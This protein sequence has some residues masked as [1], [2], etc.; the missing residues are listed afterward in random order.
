MLPFAALLQQVS[1]QILFVEPLHDDDDGP[2]F[3]VIQSAVKRLVKPRVGSLTQHVRCGFFRVQRVVHYQPVS[4]LTCRSTAN[5]RGNHVSTLVIKKLRLEVVVL[6]QLE[7]VAPPRLIPVG[8]NDGAP[9]HAVLRGQALRVT[10]ENPPRFRV[11]NPLPHRPHHRHR[12]GLHV[13]RRD[14][15]D[16]SRDLTGRHR[17]Q[18]LADEVDVPI[19]EVRRRRFNHMPRLADEVRQLPL[20]QFLSHFLQTG[21]PC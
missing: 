6:H 7:T 16:E 3:L 20:S 13:S 9:V 1:G 15:D 18:V 14:V 2:G 8:L 19:V 17:L 4:A 5:R 21:K 10:G 12:D 11:A